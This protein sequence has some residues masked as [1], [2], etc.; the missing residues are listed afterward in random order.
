MITF[1]KSLVGKAIEYY[2]CFVSCSDRDKHFATR[3]HNDLQANGVRVWFAPED[4]KI[5]DP[6]VKTID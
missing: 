1:A 2:S 5:G 4:L 3:L 6:L